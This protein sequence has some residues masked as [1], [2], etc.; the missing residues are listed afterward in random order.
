MV[1][2]GVGRKIATDKLL[3]VPEIPGFDQVPSVYD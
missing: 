1:K 3:I 2:S